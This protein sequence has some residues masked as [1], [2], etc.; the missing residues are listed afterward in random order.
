[1]ESTGIMDPVRDLEDAAG[2]AQRPVS[3]AKNTVL[4]TV[5]STEEVDSSIREFSYIWSS[6]AFDIGEPD[7]DRLGEGDGSCH[8]AIFKIEADLET[9]QQRRVDESVSVRNSFC[10]PTIQKS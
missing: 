5:L 1:M 9:L 8:I 10:D 6:G 3:E 2:P 7:T 4:Y